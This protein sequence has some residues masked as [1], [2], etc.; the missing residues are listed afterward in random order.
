MVHIS[1]YD[2]DMSSISADICSD[3]SELVS[4]QYV[5]DLSYLSFP[6]GDVDY[7]SLYESEMLFSVIV[8]SWDYKKLVNLQWKF[9]NFYLKETV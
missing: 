9:S 4:Y 1:I 8:H 5:S 7:Q 6:Y 2:S 3:L